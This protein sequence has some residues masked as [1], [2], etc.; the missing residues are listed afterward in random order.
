MVLP[1]DSDRRGNGTIVAPMKTPSDHTSSSGSHT[2]HVIDRVDDHRSGDNDRPGDLDV[3]SRNGGVPPLSGLAGWFGRPVFLEAR[4]PFELRSLRR[5]PLWNGI[6]VPDGRGAPV[7]VIPGFL[8]SPTSADSLVAILQKANWAADIAG[9]G[10]NSGPA[11]SGVEQSEQDLL[12][13]VEQHGRPVT[14][15]GHSRGGQYARILAVRH[16]EL[17]EQIVAVGAPLLTKYPRFAP[18]RV[19]IEM[20][21]ITWRRGA[22]GPVDPDLE[23]S[24]DRERY[25]PFPNTVDFVSI[26]SRNDGIVD[27]RCCIDPASTTVEVS[28][29]HTGLINSIPGVQAVADALDRQLRMGSSR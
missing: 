22:F 9:V 21:E 11:Y 8:A 28:A 18:V 27:W 17:V 5:H 13:L 1:D 10:R 14:I 15:I 25:L 26:Y 16:P 23:A 4:S 19:P 24:I 3:E 6:G 29:S 12:K 20:L 7:L 2:D